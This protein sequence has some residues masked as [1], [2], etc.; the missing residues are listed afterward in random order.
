MT[1]TGRPA[2]SG[3]PATPA[4]PASPASAGVPRRVRVTSPR[5]S[6]PRTRR[7]TPASEIDRRTALGEVYLASLLRAQL[8]LALRTLLL[9]VGLLAALPL[10]FRLAPGLAGVQVLEM[11][12]SW[13]LLAFAVYPLLVCCGWGYV[14]RAERNERTFTTMVAPPRRQDDPA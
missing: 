10:L 14:R 7:V 3:S 4:S 13:A 5:T 2:V 6:A 9:A 1:D 11:P 8:R 12:L